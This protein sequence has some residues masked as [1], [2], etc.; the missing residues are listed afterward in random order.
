MRK[1][2]FAEDEIPIFDEAVIYLRGEHWQFRSWLPGEGKYARRRLNTR[3]K[4][5]AIER[6]RD[7]DLDI[8]APLR[9][10]KRYFF[11]NAQQGDS[12]IDTFDFRRLPQL[13]RNDEAFRRSTF[14][15]Q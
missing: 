3:H 1:Q 5:T 6:E 14:E 11:V 15:A 2:A 8:M 7:R 9:A 10:G 4:R 13:D 12:Q